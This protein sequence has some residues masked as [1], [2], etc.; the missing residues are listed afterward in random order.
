VVEFLTDNTL[1]RIWYEMRQ[2]QTKLTE[3]CSYMVRRPQEV[4]LA[5]GQEPPAE[6]EQRDDLSQEELL[7]QPVHI[8]HR[9][10]KDPRELRI[11]DPAC[12][13]GHF[14]LYCFDLLRT[15]Y[16]EA[17]ADPDLSPA[18]KQDYPTWEALCR[19]VPRLILAHNLHGI[20]IDLRAT[21]IAALALWLRCQRDY[22]DMELTKDRPK[23]T[24]SNIVCA[25]P[26]PGEKEMLKEFVAEIQPPILGHLVEVVFDKMALAAEAGSLLKIE[27]E[28]RSEIASVRKQWVAEHERAVDRKGRALL[29]SQADMDRAKTKAPQKQLF[30]FSEITDEQFW[31]EAEGRVLD[32]LRDYA[33]HA[34]NGG[35]LRRQLFAEDA[36]HGFAFVDVCQKRFD[37]VLMNPPFGLV[38][39]SAKSFVFAAYPASKNDLLSAFVE[40]AI[41]MLENRGRVGAI[42]SRTGFFLS[43]F[44][45]WR[46]QVLLKNTVP[47]VFADLGAGVLD[48]AMVETAAYC[49]EKRHQA[50]QSS[51][52]LRLLRREAKPEALVEVIAQLSQGP[53]STD[54]FCVPT[55]AFISL[56]GAPFAYWISG[57]IRGLFTTHPQ[58][59]NESEA[60]TSR[61]GLGTTDNF[62]FLRLR[63]EVLESLLGQDWVSYYDGGVYSPIYDLFPLV[64]GWRDN[65][66]EIKAFVEEKMGSA[67]RNVRGEEF[68]FKPGFVFPRRTKG[69]SPK[70]MA[71][72]GIFSVGGQAG[73]VPVANL[74]W[75]IGLLSSQICSFLVSLSQGRTGDA[76]QFEVGL[77]KRLP[78]PASVSLVHKNRLE[79][80]TQAICD[81]KR[82]LTCGNELSPDFS[83]PTLLLETACAQNLANSIATVHTTMSAA[84]REIVALQQEID[85]IGYAV[86]QIHGRDRQA[87]CDTLQI[88]NVDAEAGSSEVLETV[89][90]E[91]GVSAAQCDNRGL[92]GEIVSYGVGC[93]VG[94]WD[95]RCAIGE[96]KRT[97]FPNP[98]AA[99]SAYSP[100][101]LCCQSS[102]SN[103]PPEYPL[104]IDWDG[105]LADDPEHADDVVRRV[106]DVLELIWEDRAEA[107]E[108]EACE[109]LGVKGLRD[110]FRK[111]GNGGFWADHVSRYSKSRRKAPIYWI[112]QSSKKNYALWLYYHR[113][114]KDI[115]FKALVNY[116]GPKIRMEESRLAS[117]RSQKGSGIGT[118]K[119]DKD[120]EKQEDFL[121]ELRDFEDKLRRAANLHLEPDLNDGVVLNIAPLWELVPWKEAK[122]YWEELME[123]KYEWSS[124][125]KQ[126][127]AK[128]LVK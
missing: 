60:R 91:A 72:G 108:R 86:Y 20:D 118:K 21:Q 10:K 36:G 76:A 115:L 85:E 77:V 101:R 112:L 32:A 106:R 2:G 24:R 45:E 98:F 71:G 39:H 14:L 94:R 38:S 104:R 4:F 125:G 57:R 31:T 27:E 15:I 68:Y 100:G 3:Q 37:V 53:V 43:S 119:I 63:W 69:L 113:L 65:G 29:F 48:S 89:G 55:D 30:D 25:E 84:E 1:G 102:I 7:K 95:V 11:L 111:P 78:W 50:R 122:A 40:R 44:M 41:A 17:Y 70:V 99:I 93:A 109:I 9:L 80:C 54:V 124:I 8:P 105:I 22:R 74:M 126:L 87:I 13:S 19:D 110:Y 82:M 120:I 62:R 58:F 64:V 88:Q 46:A 51:L 47:F 5:A 75:S 107:I 96:R 52:F 90:K 67:S 114:D 59:E 16:E 103:T 123:G 66:K 128:G 18:L 23:I 6:T 116:V 97:S 28:L 26:M 81:R 56:P 117:M 73:F 34:S 49:L 83:L 121:S 42:T 79:V 12:G 35:R 127:R 33:S 61:C 92:V